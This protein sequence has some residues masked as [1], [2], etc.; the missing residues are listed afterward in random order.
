[1]YLKTYLS[2]TPNKVDQTQIQTQ[3][4]GLKFDQ[5]QM[6]IQIRSICIC[7]SKYK[8]RFCHPARITIDVIFL[9]LATKLWLNFQWAFY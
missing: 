7:I 5:I 3:I 2:N 9:G 6:H 1:M 8:I 4:R